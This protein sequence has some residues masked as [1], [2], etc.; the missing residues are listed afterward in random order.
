MSGAG[1]GGQAVLVAFM[2]ARARRA[3]G[4][5]PTGPGG[6]RDGGATRAP[7]TRFKSWWVSAVADVAFF[8]PPGLSRTAQPGRMLIANRQP[9][10][11]REFVW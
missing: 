8:L 7:T 6:C 2:G 10:R 5:T 4:A 11:S 9:N 1:V 3:R